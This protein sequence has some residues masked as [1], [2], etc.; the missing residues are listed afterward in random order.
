MAGGP[1]PASPGV[2][3]VSGL[4]GEKKKDKVSD[5]VSSIRG[6]DF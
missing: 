5:L 4:G 1:E 2:G 6:N 3:E